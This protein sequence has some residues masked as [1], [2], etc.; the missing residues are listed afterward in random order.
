MAAYLRLA[1]GHAAEAGHADR[2]PHRAAEVLHRCDVPTRALAAL[3]YLS[4]S[5]RASGF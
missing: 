2:D 3:E 4:S 5:R 1:E